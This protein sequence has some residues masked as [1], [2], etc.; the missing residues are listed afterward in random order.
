MNISNTLDL[1]SE[2][3][4]KVLL[5]KSMGDC[6]CYIKDS[7]VNS[8][9]DPKCHKCVGTGKI[10]GIFLTEKIRTQNERK[11]STEPED[12]DGYSLSKDNE[13]FFFKDYYDF[14]NN[15]D[16]ICTLEFNSTKPLKLYKITSKQTF[17]YNNFYFLE[18]TGEKIQFSY[19]LNE[20]LKEV[21]QW[22]N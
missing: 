21:I 9:P 12:K 17:I 15:D 2:T 13:L 7:L 3:G 20:L 19:S 11:N 16:L 10:R 14:I 8:E 1:I 5:L 22:I 6:D 18:V 4:E